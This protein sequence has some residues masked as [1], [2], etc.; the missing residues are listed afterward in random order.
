MTRLSF[1]GNKRGILGGFVVTFVATILIVIILFVFVLA[2]GIVKTFEVKGNTVIERI[3]NPQSIVALTFS[4]SLNFVEGVLKEEFYFLLAKYNSSKS[5]QDRAELQEYILENKVD[6]I[7]VEI[8]AL[9]ARDVFCCTSEC[10]DGACVYNFQVFLHESL[11]SFFVAEV[12]PGWRVK[13][14]GIAVGVKPNV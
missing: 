3:D 7:G 9:D 5:S 13:V 11:G 8:S 12:F 4:D 6:E 14:G 1:F 2:G 10:V